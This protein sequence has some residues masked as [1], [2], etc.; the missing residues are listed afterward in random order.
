M[1]D[2][3]LLQAFEVKLDLLAVSVSLVLA[4]ASILVF[5]VVEVLDAAQEVLVAVE[6]VV[7]QL[8]S[9]AGPAVAPMG[10]VAAQVAVQVFGTAADL[11]A[12]YLCL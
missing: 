9:E 8:V 2:E 3:E 5:A 1:M 4:A 11:A 6:V 12:N 7:L 10:F